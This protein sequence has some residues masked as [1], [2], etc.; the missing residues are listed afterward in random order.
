[1]WPPTLIPEAT[2][3]HAGLLVPLEPFRISQLAAIFSELLVS[4]ARNI[5]DA[6]LIVSRHP[7]APIFLIQIEGSVV[8][9]DPPKFWQE[10]PDLVGLASRAFPRQV[11]LFYLESAPERREGFMVAQQ[12]QVLAADDATQENIPAGATDA[13]WPV[14]RLCQQLRIQKA[15]LE[16]DFAGGPSVRAK[17]VEPA[18]IDDQALLMKLVGREPGGAP[19]DGAAPAPTPGPGQAGPPQGQAQAA[20]PGPKKETVEDDAKRREK[21]KQAE[22]A[23][24]AK[25]SEEVRSGLRYTI[26][27][28][29]LV[30]APK[31]ELSEPEVLEPF[32][33]GSVAGDLP[34][35]LPRDLTRELQG[36]RLDVAV[37]VDFMSEVFVENTPLSKATFVERATEGTVG[38]RSV[39]LLEVLGPRLGYGTLISSGKAPHIFVSR[40]MGVPLPEGL[41]AELL[42]TPK[43]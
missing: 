13:D 28:L 9:G 25:R 17:M 3:K 30:A 10:N 29:G 12:G 33:V 6:E 42:D 27:D 37:Q 31:A 39:K 1:M 35:G 23:E 20:A 14:A 19:A 43:A 22:A 41:I 16:S 21:E 38:G 24:Q 7:T 40:K 36:K 32:V 11:I 15:D 4:R 8:G 5:L 2:S 26:D 18:Q 34:D